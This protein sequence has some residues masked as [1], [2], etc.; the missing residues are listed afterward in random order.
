MKSVKENSLKVPCHELTLKESILLNP[1]KEYHR[2][3]FN[4]PSKEKTIKKKTIKMNLLLFF[5]IIFIIIVICRFMSNFKRMSIAEHHSLI[6]HENVNIND[7]NDIAIRCFLLEESICCIDIGLSKNHWEIGILTNKNNGFLI[8]TSSSNAIEVFRGCF[9]GKH[10]K[11]GY[12]KNMDRKTNIISTSKCNPIKINT[13]IYSEL[14]RIKNHPYSLLYDNCHNN[15]MYQYLNII[16]EKPNKE[17]INI[18]NRKYGFSMF[19]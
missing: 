17:L 3:I 19:F 2:R 14:N 11:Y 7:L 10:F 8:S 15:A 5:V 13:I 12:E 9:D 4:N 6:I 16:G 1:L 18:L